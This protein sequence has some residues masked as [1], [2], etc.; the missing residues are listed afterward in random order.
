MQRLLKH[1]AKLILGILTME[2]LR[3]P[4]KLRCII[5]DHRIHGIIKSPG[6]KIYTYRSLPPLITWGGFTVLDVE[7]LT[8]LPLPGG[9]SGLYVRAE[10]M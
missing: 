5:R 10:K 8:D 3:L 2:G 4:D 6:T 1:G 9:F 7:H